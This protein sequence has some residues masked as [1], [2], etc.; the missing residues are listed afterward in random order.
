[1]LLAIIAWVVPASGH[2]TRA[3]EV[4]PGAT[5]P[6]PTRGHGTGWKTMGG[7]KYYYGADG[8]PMVG[9]G[10]IDGVWYYFDSAGEGGHSRNYRRSHRCSVHVAVIVPHSPFKHY[11]AVDILSRRCD[12]A[13][14]A[15]VRKPRPHEA[16]GGDG[17]LNGTDEI[18]FYSTHGTHVA[19]IIAAEAGN[20]GVLGVA[21]GGGTK[22][23]NRLVSLSS[24]DIFSCIGKDDA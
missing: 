17:Y 10:K 18:P 11:C 20:G 1:M 16:I 8:K 12:V 2:R 4:V 24:I 23:A 14:I 19:G 5:D 22:L 21:S 9:F 15:V 13:P 6:L 7:N 3:L